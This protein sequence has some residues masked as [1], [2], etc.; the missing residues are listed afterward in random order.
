MRSALQI[1][2]RRRRS[3]GRRWRGARREGGLYRRILQAVGTPGSGAEELVWTC[4]AAQGGGARRRRRGLR[5]RRGVVVHGGGGLA[6]RGGGAQRRQED[7]DE[8][9]RDV[10]MVV[11]GFLETVLTEGWWELSERDPHQI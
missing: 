8:R 10:R 3:E 11:W 7:G 6:L 1:T 4:E 5:W 2:R 9:S